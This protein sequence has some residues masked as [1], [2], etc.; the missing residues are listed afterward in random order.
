MLAIRKS[1]KSVAKKLDA[2]RAEKAKKSGKTFHVSQDQQAA[3]D[4]A[5]DEV[6]K[7]EERAL[8]DEQIKEKM[9]KFKI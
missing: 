5:N 1:P 2:K 7:P 9:K 4:K 8:T 6:A 3:L